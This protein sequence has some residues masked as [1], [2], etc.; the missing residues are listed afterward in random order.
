M[1]ID[2]NLILR[3]IFFKLMLVEL[4]GFERELNFIKFKVR[5]LTQDAKLKHRELQRMQQ[6]FLRKDIKFINL[7]NLPYKVSEHVP[8]ALVKSLRGLK[9]ERIIA[10]Y[11]DE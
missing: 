2:R 11:K 8:T 3:S 7:E 9:F 1:T 4:P 10:Q 6:C 5:L